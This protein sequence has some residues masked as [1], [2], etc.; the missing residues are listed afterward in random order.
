M[1]QKGTL[2]VHADLYGAASTIGK[3]REFESVALQKA[4]FPVQWATGLRV[5]GVL[6]PSRR[7]FK[8]D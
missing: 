8:I 4:A 3:D 6:A 1:L 7:I 2:Y 5:Q